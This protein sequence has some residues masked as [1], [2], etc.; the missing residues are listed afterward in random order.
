[1]A[2][3]GPVEEHVLHLGPGADVVNDPALAGTAGRFDDNPNVGESVAVEIPGHDVA[4]GVVRHREA[5]LQAFPVPG[6]VFLEVG[7]SAVVDVLVRAFEPPLLRILGEMALHVFVDALLEIDPEGA[8]ATHDDVTADTFVGSDVTTRIVED[9][10]GRIVGHGDLGSGDGGLGQALTEWNGLGFGTGL[11]MSQEEGEADDSQGADESVS[12]ECL[13]QLMLAACSN[14]VANSRRLIQQRAPM[15]RPK[16]A[17]MSMLVSK[18][19]VA[20]KPSMM[21]KRFMIGM[22]LFA[23]GTAL[24]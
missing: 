24:P 12:H 22:G 20:R 21:V 7:D 15:N 18:P 6:E 14:Q 1:M 23:P 2:D 9:D 5:L 19:P 11:S 17:R 8:I 16:S 13:G 3:D 4:D 10:I